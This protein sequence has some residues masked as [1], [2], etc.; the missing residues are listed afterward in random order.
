M[1]N[2]Y[3]HKKNQQKTTRR[4]VPIN[5]VQTKSHKRFVIGK[6]GQLFCRKKPITTIRTGNYSKNNRRDNGFWGLFASAVLIWI[7]LM[8]FKPQMVSVASSISLFQIDEIEILG[9]QM[10]DEA[11]ISALADIK[12]HTSMLAVDITKVE[13]RIAQ[14]AWIKEVNIAKVWPGKIVINIDEYS[15]EAIVVDQLSDNKYYMNRNGVVFSRVLPGYDMDFPF[16]TGITVENGQKISAKFN[17]VIEFIKYAKKNNPSLPIQNISELH[18][19]SARRLVVF[20]ADVSF[21]IYFGH[22]DIKQKYKRVSEMMRVLYR[23]DRRDKIL[24]NILEIKVDYQADKILVVQKDS[25]I[26]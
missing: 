9:C 6:I 24:S 25:V 21:P 5:N 22:G 26:G 19:D 11:Q 15:P 1:I 17:D 8:M 12:Y 10:L 3:K 13:Q 4:P 7:F 18:I 2:I 20:L 16:I 14:Q 23:M